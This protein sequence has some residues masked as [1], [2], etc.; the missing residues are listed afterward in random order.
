LLQKS[1]ELSQALAD[2]LKDLGYQVARPN[3]PT[4]TT[5]IVNVTAGP[6][7]ALKDL[8]AMSRALV[9]Y[10]I[11]FAKRGPGLRL[12]P[13]AHNNRDDIHETL[14]VFAGKVRSGL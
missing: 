13:H 5:P 12:S 9:K 1:L 10:K 11:S 6:R 2:G 7:T 3:G 8:D 14:R 4:L